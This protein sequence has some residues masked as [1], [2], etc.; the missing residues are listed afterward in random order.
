[1]MN[2]DIMPIRPIQLPHDFL[3]LADAITASFQYPENEE[4]S[5]QPDEKADIVEQ[6]RMMRRLWPLVKLLQ[7]ISPS[8]RDLITGYI[9]EEDEQ[10]AGMVLLHRIGATENWIIGTVGVLPA[11]RRRGMARQLVEGGLKLIREKEGKKVILSVIDGNEPARS[12][13]ESVGFQQYSGTVEFE[14]KPNESTGYKTGY[15]NEGQWPLEEP[16]LPSGYRQAPLGRFEWQPRYK[17]IKRIAPELVQ[18]Y[19]AIDE[20][21][22]RPTTARRLL[23]FLFAFI[24]SI[25]GKRQERFAIWTESDNQVVAVGKCSGST[26]G[27]GFSDL[28][29]TLDA[30]H[31]ALAPYLVRYQ[32]IQALRINPKHRVSL[33]VDQWMSSIVAAA[34]EAGFVRRQEDCS[35]GLTL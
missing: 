13:Y 27:D 34:E 26:R 16:T 2:Q 22:Y 1:M 23:G 33:S 10:I 11:Y 8:L 5:I 9:W 19:E 12:L 4:W 28:D 3:P 35:M 20:K 29:I 18:T 21:R 30:N 25:Q 24:G 15:K 32:L 31:D 7:R 6:V 17:L 14:L